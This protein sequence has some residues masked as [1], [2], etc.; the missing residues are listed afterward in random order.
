M[1]QH[2]ENNKDSLH[3]IACWAANETVAMPDLSIGSIIFTRG[4]GGM[5]INLQISEWD[6]KDLFA[7]SGID[8]D[9]G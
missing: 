8:E 9:T 3:H 4:L 2:Q 5:S 6:Y 1:T 7:G